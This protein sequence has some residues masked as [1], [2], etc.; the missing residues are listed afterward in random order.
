VDRL[1]IDNAADVK[2]LVRS[3]QMIWRAELNR[4]T[5]QGRVLSGLLD[6]NPIACGIITGGVA[7]ASGMPPALSAASAMGGGLIT[8]LLKLFGNMAG[9]AGANARDRAVSAHF[10]ALE[11]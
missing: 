11:G 10:M 8:P 4:L 5:G 9:K 6:T 3:K 1:G 2:T 7:A